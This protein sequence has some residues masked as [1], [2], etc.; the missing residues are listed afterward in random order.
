MKNFRFQLWYTGAPMGDNEHEVVATAFSESG[1][2]KLF[3][4]QRSETRLYGSNSKIVDLKNPG[5]HV[6]EPA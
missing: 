1:L 2:K 6:E 5:K 4:R 3:K